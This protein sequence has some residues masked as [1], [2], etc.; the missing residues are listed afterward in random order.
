MLSDRL[1]VMDL[2]EEYRHMDDLSLKEWVVEFISR[3]TKFMGEYSKLSDLEDSEKKKAILELYKNYEIMVPL[4][5]KYDEEK[6]IIE[7]FPVLRAYRIFGT[8]NTFDVNND[9]IHRYTMRAQG[10]SD[11]MEDFKCNNECENAKLCNF[12]FVDD[13]P[14]EALFFKLLG[15]YFRE[16]NVFCGDRLTLSINMEATKDEIRKEFEKVL[17]IHHPETNTKKLFKKWKYYMIVYDL[18]KSNK[19]SYKN[20]SELLSQTYVDEKELYEERNIINYY[21]KSC[22]L[23]SGGYAQYL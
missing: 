2:A 19:V 20:I 12:D 23:I 13:Q 1:L 4:L 8:P 3:N 14:I 9:E 15:L 16:G 10:L 21:E 11:K 22:S 17:A 5:D 7:V 6:P 18:K